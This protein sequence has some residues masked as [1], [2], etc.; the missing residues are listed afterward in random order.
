MMLN[1]ALWYNMEFIALDKKGKNDSIRKI[2]GVPNE[3]R[4]VKSNRFF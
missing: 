1:P 2:I 4:Y 3:Q